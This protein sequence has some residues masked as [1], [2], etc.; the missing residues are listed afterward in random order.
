MERTPLFYL[1]NLGSEV[2][3]IFILKEKG[4]LK[5]AERA[6]AR[7]MDIVEKLLSHP[8]LEGRTWE[9]E[10]LKDYLEQSMISDRVRF[11]KQEWQRYFSPY[12][13]RLFPSN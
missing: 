13:N 10:I 4:L 7:A 11:F 5:E 9:I 6:Y 3:R 2:N 1:A 12:A 8:D